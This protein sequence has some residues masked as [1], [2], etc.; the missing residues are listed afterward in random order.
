MK[1]K[2]TVHW[3]K[4]AEDSAHTR[5]L[6][7]IPDVAAF[8]FDGVKFANGGGERRPRSVIVRSGSW[9]TTEHDTVEEA[10][11]WVEDT[12]IATGEWEDV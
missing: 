9:T 6:V 11:H 4:G 10:T 3:R 5:S 2:G 8:V 7:G 1:K 12:L